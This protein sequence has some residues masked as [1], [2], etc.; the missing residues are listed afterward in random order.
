ME[1]AGRR[2][3][4][5]EALRAVLAPV[6]E[7]LLLTD[8][9]LFMQAL[10]TMAVRSMALLTMAL[11]TMAVLTNGWTHYSC[12]SISAADGPAVPLAG[13]LDR[14]PPASHPQHPI[15][16]VHSFIHRTVH[17]IYRSVNRHPLPPV[18]LTAC[19]RRGATP[20]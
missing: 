20:N 11:L 7:T 3:A 2:L 10:L 16:G 13:E 14:G 8:Q 6:V 4:A 5:F 18:D 12:K 15:H 9:L 19:R 17:P 1:A